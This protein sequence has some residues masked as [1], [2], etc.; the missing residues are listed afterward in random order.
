V[1]EDA[2]LV[3]GTTYSYR[4]RATNAAG[5]S[6]WSSAASATTLTGDNDLRV[7][8]R[9]DGTGGGVATDPG[10]AG[11]HGSL[12][13]GP[14]WTTSGQLG[15][16][17]S[18]DGVDDRVVVPDSPDLRFGGTDSFTLAAWV[19]LTSLPGKWTS[20]VAKA[21]GAAAGWYG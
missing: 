15:G 4:V 3:P 10:P 12:V 2:G 19:N 6:P 18:F 11:L 20:V 21:R 9:F 17:L 14:S 5:T 7:Y 16:A 13:S 1:F 8:D